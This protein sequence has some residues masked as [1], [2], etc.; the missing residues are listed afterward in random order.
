M[1]FS[2]SIDNRVQEKTTMLSKRIKQYWKD[3][4]WVM[5]FIDP[6]ALL[7]PV[8]LFFFILLQI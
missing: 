7:L 5:D 4:L 2:V 3:I 8:L 6:I 1:W